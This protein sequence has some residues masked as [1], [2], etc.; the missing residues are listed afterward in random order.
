M[1]S[2]TQRSAFAYP[3]L[4]YSALSGLD[5]LILKHFGKLQLCIR[6]VP[7]L[8]AYG[9]M[10]PQPPSFSAFFGAN[11]NAISYKPRRKRRAL[12]LL[13]QS[14]MRSRAYLKNLTAAC[15]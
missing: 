4:H 6:L 1:E 11:L 8:S 5:T 12:T 13:R 14:H 3:G 9:Q 15:L 2:R 7:Y 10:S